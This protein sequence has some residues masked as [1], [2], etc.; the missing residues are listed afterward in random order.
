MHASAVIIGAEFSE[1][2]MQIDRIPEERAIEEFAPDRPDRS[3][4]ERVRHRGIRCRAVDVLAADAKADDTPRENIDDPKDSMAAKQDGLAT[5]LVHAPEA[6]LGLRDEGEPGGAG[7]AWMFRAIVF[8]EHPADDIL[9]IRHAV[10]VRDLLGNALIPES[11]VAALHLEDGGD[12]LLRRAPV[13]ENRRRYFRSSSSSSQAI[14]ET[15]QH[16]T[17]RMRGPT[18]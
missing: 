1:L 5:T 12:D 10:C 8:C 3:F 4:D 9:I 18:P 17:A 11:G 6:V 13:D 15:N 14:R 2:P 7:S 16:K